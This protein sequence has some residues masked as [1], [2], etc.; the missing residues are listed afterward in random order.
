MTVGG[1]ER[2]L[3]SGLTEC[4]NW[5]VLL[6]DL[7]IGINYRGE[8]HNKKHVTIHTCDGGCRMADAE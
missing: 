5:E 4:E 2:E 7:E 3:R 8:M 1:K 6:Q